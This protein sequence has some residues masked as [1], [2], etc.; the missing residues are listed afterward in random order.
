MAD[1]ESDTAFIFITDYGK[2]P[3]EIVTYKQQEHSF[4]WTLRLSS[5]AK[6]ARI[7]ISEFGKVEL[8]WPRD[9]S[10]AHVPLMMEQHQGWV[11]QKLSHLSFRQQCVVPPSN[12]VF[13]VV[14]EIWNVAYIP[15]QTGRIALKEKDA[16]IELHGDLAQGERVRKALCKWLK[17]K[18]KVHLGTM[19]TETADSMGLKYHSL[20]IRLQKN[21]WGSCSQDGR[22]NLN[23]ALVFLPVELARHVMIHEL[24]HLRHLNHSAAFWQEVSRFEPNYL[25]QRKK[26]RQY[27]NSVPAWLTHE[28]EKENELVVL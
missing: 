11:K 7:T 19:L 3:E 14:D 9:L 6:R 24:T 21:R 23:G 22:I 25:E 16:C 13:S 4:A 2:L 15:K 1:S 12:I 28:F 8:V 17:G 20:S 5:R 10:Q 26:L 18:A 27:S